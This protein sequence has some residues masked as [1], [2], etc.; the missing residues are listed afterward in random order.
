MLRTIEKLILSR[1]YLKI[2]SS[3]LLTNN[4][5]FSKKARCLHVYQK[6]C[7]FY[8]SVSNKSLTSRWPKDETFLIQSKII[9]DYTHRVMFMLL[10]C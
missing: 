2:L 3:Y 6:N 1:I 7:Y 4:Y 9:K 8:L 5:E 10:I